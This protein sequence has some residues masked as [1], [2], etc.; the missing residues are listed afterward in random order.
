M[1]FS[2][3]RRNSGIDAVRLEDGRVIL[4]AN[5]VA[6]NWAART[7]L[8]LL[9]SS[10]GGETW[11]GRI[12]VET[13]PGEY[14]YPALITTPTGVALSYTWNRRRIAFI[15]IPGRALPGTATEI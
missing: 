3:T 9:V 8:S 11:P 2:L 10:D 15:E 12:D 6:G 14:S 13:D 1:G 7:P 5:P 4:A